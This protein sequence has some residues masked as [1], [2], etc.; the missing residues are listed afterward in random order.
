MEVA[1]SRIE[2]FRKIPGLLQKYY[3]RLD[4]PNH[5]G[6]VYV[7]DSKASLQVYRQSDLAQSIP[8]AYK[9]IGTPSVEVLDVV[10]PL[11]EN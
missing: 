2:Q 11:R 8:E 3:V 10:I 7:W 9:V 4:K 6:G 1:E 5:F